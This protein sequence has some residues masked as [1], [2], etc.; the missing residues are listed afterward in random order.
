MKRRDFVQSMML[1]GAALP[2]LSPA[3]APTPAPAPAPAAAAAGTPPVVTAPGPDRM[4]VLWAV[5]SYA[6]GW[7][8]YGETDQL[9]QRADGE[10]GPGFIARGDRVLR[11]RLSGLR[12]GTRY[13]AQAVTVPS[14]FSYTAKSACTT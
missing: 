8:E 3:Q 12:P 14:A 10:A 9:G 5:S 2:L 7:V 1:G 4:T 6:R 13:H 11:V